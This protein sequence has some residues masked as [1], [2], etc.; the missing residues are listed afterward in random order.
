[1]E[2]NWLL[3]ISGIVGMVM[4]T[5]CVPAEPPSA[6]VQKVEAAGSG[7]LSKT[8]S[9][10]IQQWLGPHRELAIEVENMCKAV[11]PKATAKWADSTEGRVC[12]AS[13]QLAFY[14]FTPD[15]GDGKTFKGGWK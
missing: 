15:K 2:R 9:D 8:S 6:I 14:R 5:A 12:T 13:S 10:G 3:G 4:M 7:D 11:R 1:M